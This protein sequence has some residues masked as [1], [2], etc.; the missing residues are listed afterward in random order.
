MERKYPLHAISTHGAFPQVAFR[1]FPGRTNQVLQR[2]Y[3]AGGWI[4]AAVG[5]AIVW[6]FIALA[7]LYVLWAIAIE[8]LA[9]SQ[10]AASSLLS[11]AVAVMSRCLGT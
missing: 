4:L 11:A 5:M 9:Q 1:R 3:S 2:W 6:I 10:P 7:A 8:A